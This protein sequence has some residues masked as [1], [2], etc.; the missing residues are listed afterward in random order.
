[1]GKGRERGVYGIRTWGVGA[2][3]GGER[4]EA[5]MEEQTPGPHCLGVGVETRVHWLVAS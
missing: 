3:K 1:M 5:G 4:K 2:E